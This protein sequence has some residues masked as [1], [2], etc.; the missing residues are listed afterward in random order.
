MAVFEF[1]VTTGAP[2]KATAAV[3]SHAVR[4]G[5][6]RK[7]AAHD[8]GSLKDSQLVIRQ[9]SRLKGRFR[10]SPINAKE[11]PPKATKGT[12]DPPLK[13]RL[14]TPSKRTKNSL[15][16]TDLDRWELSRYN[17]YSLA[18]APSQSWGDPFSTL[19]ITHSQGMDN[20]VKY[21]K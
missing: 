19:P 1:V 17:S 8:A 21:C 2:Q 12:V 4:S 14:R 20:L 6:E 9:K 7:C 18:K 5:L 16:D 10:L 11:A 3:R 13:E 15:E